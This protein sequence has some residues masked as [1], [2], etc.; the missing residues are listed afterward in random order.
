MSQTFEE[1][2]DIILRDFA[3]RVENIPRGKTYGWSD[4]RQAI[5]SLIEEDVVGLDTTHRP[6]RVYR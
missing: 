4:E 2:L 3:K 6:R 5:L 1:K